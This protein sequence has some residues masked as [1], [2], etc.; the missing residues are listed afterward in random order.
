M[1]HSGNIG[2]ASR[3]RLRTDSGGMEPEST[4]N[5]MGCL[6]WNG[7]ASRRVFHIAGGIKVQERC[8]KD[9]N[10]EREYRMVGPKRNLCGSMGDSE[11]GSRGYC[12]Y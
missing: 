5:G 10:I 11:H 4:P 8:P 9:P 12:S 7:A 1:T 6:T 3:L 2:T